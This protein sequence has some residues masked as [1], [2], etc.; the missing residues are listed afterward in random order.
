MHFGFDFTLIT[1]ILLFTVSYPTMAV[2][3][4]LCIH[5]PTPPC[6][7]F[8]SPEYTIICPSVVMKCPLPPHLTSANPHISIL[9]LSISLPNTWVFPS[10]NILLMFHV[11]TLSLFLSC[12]AVVSILPLIPSTI[13]F[14]VV[15]ALPV[16]VVAV[17]LAAVAV[18]AV[19]PVADFPTLSWLPNRGRG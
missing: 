4:L 5:T 11:P 18:L 10:C 12:I 17:A 8:S 16:P 2:V 3:F 6:P 7:C 14:A 15:P 9:N 1:K 13:V 19:L